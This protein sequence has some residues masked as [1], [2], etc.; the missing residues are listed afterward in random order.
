MGLITFGRDF[1][2]LRELDAAAVDYWIRSQLGSELRTVN[3]QTL[4]CVAGNVLGLTEDGARRVRLAYLGI[5]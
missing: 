1:V 4:R 3:G 5:G 2:M